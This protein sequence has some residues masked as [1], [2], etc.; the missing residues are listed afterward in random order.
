MASCYESQVNEEVTEDAGYQ[1]VDAEKFKELLADEDI[2]VVDVRTADEYN[3]GTIDGAINIDV[4][5]SDFKTNIAE[6]DKSKKTLIFCR[7][8]G[9]S[10]RAGAVMEE[11]GFATVVDLSGGY[12]SWPYK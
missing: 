6:L 8:G 11:M 9:R 3:S 4:T 10:A 7:S 1:V 5:A 2:Q 12:M